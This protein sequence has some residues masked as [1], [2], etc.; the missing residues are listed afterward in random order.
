[1]KGSLKKILPPSVVK[2]LPLGTHSPQLGPALKVLAIHC[3][4]EHGTVRCEGHEEVAR[5]GHS[6]KVDKV[7]LVRTEQDCVHALQL[8]RHRV[9]PGRLVVCVDG[10]DRCCAHDRTCQVGQALRRLQT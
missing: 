2:H 4:L 6:I 1:M 8:M 10:S 7:R 5:I 3:R 9:V